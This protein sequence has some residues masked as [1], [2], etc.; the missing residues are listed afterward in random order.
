M[1]YEIKNASISID[2]KP[3]LK[4][5]DFRL[6]DHDKIG[7]V[8]RNGGGKTTM[9]KVISGELDIEK[10]EVVLGEEQDL[11]NNE[12]IAKDF[13]FQI[14]YEVVKKIDNIQAKIRYAAKFAECR[15]E[16]LEDEKYKIIFEV[17]QRSITK[18]QSVVLYKN[19]I[20]L[21]GGIIA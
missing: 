21:G 9:L 14:D 1:L 20:L 7:I 2:G 15:I 12:L 16:K 8:G 11:H 17:P 4:N 3:I 19:N 5:F 13:N 10:N 6:V 18:G